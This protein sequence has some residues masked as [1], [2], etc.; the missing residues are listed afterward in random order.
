MARN[1]QDLPK[2][3]HIKTQIAVIA[4]SLQIHLDGLRNTSAAERVTEA[5]QMEEVLTALN[6]HGFQLAHTELNTAQQV[7]G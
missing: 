7:C 2:H 6:A 5:R 3:I 1:S 4:L